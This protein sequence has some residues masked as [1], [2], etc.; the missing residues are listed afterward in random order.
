[1]ETGDHDPGWIRNKHLKATKELPI[2]VYVDLPKR[3]FKKQKTPTGPSLRFPIPPP[4]PGS[5]AWIG[6]LKKYPPLWF[7][8]FPSEFLLFRQC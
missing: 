8:S 2:F 3:P 7:L 5:S 4:P 6:R 1:M